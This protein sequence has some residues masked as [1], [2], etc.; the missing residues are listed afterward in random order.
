MGE[1]E[2]VRKSL[3]RA[4]L[5]PRQEKG[6]GGI[7]IITSLYKL[8]RQNIFPP[9]LPAKMSTPG[10]TFNTILTSAFLLKSYIISETQFV[11]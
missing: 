3:T 5:T 2:V 6:G 10:C 7:N 1:G 4:H 9:K 8:T 11:G